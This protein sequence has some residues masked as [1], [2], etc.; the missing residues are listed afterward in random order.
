MSLFTKKTKISFFIVLVMIAT[1]IVADHKSLD[2]HFALYNYKPYSPKEMAGYCT[3]IDDDG[4]WNGML[5][6]VDICNS[7]D[8]KCSFAIINKPCDSVYSN[9]LQ[10]LKKANFDIVSHT[11]HRNFW[12]DSDSSIDSIENDIEKSAQWSKKYGMNT[13]ALVYPNGIINKDIAKL[14]QKHNYHLGFSVYTKRQIFA[15][16]D[17]GQY[18]VKRVF[19]DKKQGFTDFCRHVDYCKKH[20]LWLN[21]ASHSW[22]EEQWSKEYADSCI[23]YIISKGFK[24]ITVSQADS[25]LFTRP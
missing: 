15:R 7:N 10:E 20:D 16:G 18:D 11:S 6:V 14:L 13:I 21:I 4:D 5:K 25:I 2:F 9:H 8:I 3:W 12:G 23:K 17:Y 22:M 19:I 1:L 24:F